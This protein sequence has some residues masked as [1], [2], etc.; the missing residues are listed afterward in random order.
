MRVRPIRDLPHFRDLRAFLGHL[1]E[2]K[3]LAH[4]TERVS[5]VHEMTEIHRRVLA[6]GGP[7]LLFEL[8]TRNDG[9]TAEMR[10]L[11][12]LFGT[13][14]R[15]AWGLG[16]KRPRLGELG[17]LLAALRELEPIDG[18]RGAL[19][20][21]PLLKAA[22]ATIPV[23]VA[24]PPVQQKVH[25]G[26]QIDLGRLPIQ[27][28]W[29]GEPAP[30]ITWP[31][32]ITRS[33]DQDRTLD[34]NM[35][36]YR[37]QVLGPNRAIVRWLSH[38]GGAAHHRLW[39]AQGHDMPVAIVIG[40][41]PATMLSAVLPLPEGMS[42]L[43]FSGI[44]RGERPRLARCLTVPLMVPADAEIV[45]EGFVSA[46]ETALEGPFGDHTGYYNAVEP[47]PVLRVT[48][49]TTREAPIYVSTFTGRPPDEPSIIGEA[50]N[51]LFI[52]ILRRQIPEVRDCWFPPDACSYRMAIVSIQK[53]YAGQAR[54]VMM[55][56][57]GML[58][59]FSY[60][61]VI[62]VVDDD[63]DVRDWRDISWALATR[64]DPSR[65]LMVTDHTPIDYL[66]F[67]SPL[68]GLGGKLGID[69][70][71]KT[72][73]E[74]SREWGRVLAMDPAVSRRIDDLWERLGLGNAGN[75]SNSY[76]RGS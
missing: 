45:I 12:N 18:L 29:P 14:E 1:D 52:P 75:S 53:R 39:A 63:I 66:D 59:Q 49:V 7:A 37:M 67:A 70:T 25:I 46:K 34:Y 13:V 41:D 42:E 30:L 23:N 50:L 15:V 48:A 20:R 40:A 32:V 56:L 47:F 28:C 62:I 38:R 10:V 65:D 36:I 60:T 3:L 27:I 21:W 5:T 68:A 31:L 2:G 64:M 6:C 8:A 61:K 73:S 51:E 55:A 11:V 16:V 54:R 44:L 72:G 69:A 19:Q 43:R 24:R 71:N 22:F 57:W 33:P 76:A 17:E 58:V 35:G 74:T 4:V 26:A 9:S